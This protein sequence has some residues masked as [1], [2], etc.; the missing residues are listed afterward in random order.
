[1]ISVSSPRFDLPQEAQMSQ[2]KKA[3]FVCH[4]CNEVGHKAIACPQLIPSLKREQGANNSDSVP[5]TRPNL[6]LK[7]DL[8]PLDQVTCFKVR[9]NPLVYFQ[10]SFWYSTSGILSHQ[11]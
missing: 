3:N 4:F 7:H 10:L 2:A 9:V 11:D 8:R 6:S 1:M 5:S